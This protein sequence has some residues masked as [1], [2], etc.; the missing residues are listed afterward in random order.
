M[1]NSNSFKQRCKHYLICI[2]KFDVFIDFAGI[3]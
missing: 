1:I 2:A 3:K